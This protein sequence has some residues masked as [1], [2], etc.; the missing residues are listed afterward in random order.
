MNTETIVQ[1]VCF[2]SPLGPEDF[3]EVWEPFAS[4]LVNDRKHILLKEAIPE[5]KGKSFTYMSQHSC[6]ATDFRFAFMKG[7]GATSLPEQKATFKLAGGYLPV[8]SRNAYH[9]AKTDARIIAFV[10]GGEAELDF[11]RSQAF[12]HLSIYE[13]YYENC[14]Y[15]YVLEI[16]LPQDDAPA[17]LSLLKSTKGVEASRYEECSLK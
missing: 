14:A 8:Q 7:K 4:Q 2:T 17:L 5:K 10:T 9:K 12:S 16:F 11:Y 1:F 15:S 13:A 6:R 3:R